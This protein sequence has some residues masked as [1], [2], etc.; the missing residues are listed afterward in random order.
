MT[1]TIENLLVNSGLPGPRG[2][3]ELL[4]SF[5]HSATADEI[6]ECLA[7]CCD[8][9]KNSPA[10]FVAMCGIVGYCILNRDNIKEMLEKIRP[11]ASHQSWRIREAVAIGIQEVAGSN[12]NQVINYLERWLSG[13]EL[14]RRAVVA[15][16]CEPKLLRDGSVNIKILNILARLTVEFEKMGSK[17]SENQSTLRKALGYGWSV[18]IVS[19]PGEGKKVFE[20]VAHNSNKH[21]QWISKEN[22]K[23]KRLSAMDRR[24]VEKMVSSLD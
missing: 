24:W 13:N 23:K 10:E 15:A 17:L 14:E 12:M 18:V 6:D 5:A 20:T 8:D 21:I 4:Y 7:Y 11:Y 16:L 2:N 1:K 3:L 9:L 22:L 19:I